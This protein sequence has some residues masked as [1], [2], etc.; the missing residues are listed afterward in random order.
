MENSL[1]AAESISQLPDIDV[2]MC[3]S[4][5]L[6]FSRSHAVSLPAR[7]LA[8]GRYSYIAAVLCDDLALLSI[9]FTAASLSED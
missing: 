5:L 2:T 6:A 8:P 9:P 1:D 4:L 7:C 3:V